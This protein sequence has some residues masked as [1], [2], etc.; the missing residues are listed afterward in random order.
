MIIVVPR[1]DRYRFY[2]AEARSSQRKIILNAL[3]PRRLC[4]ESNSDELVQVTDDPG[5]DIYPSWNPSHEWIA[6]SS[7]R[8]SGEGSYDIFSIHEPDTEY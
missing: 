6:F 5:T 8:H 3:R 4:E 1:S 2:L 7:D